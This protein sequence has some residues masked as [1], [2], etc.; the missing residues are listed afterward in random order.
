MANFLQIILQK[1]KDRIQRTVADRGLDPRNLVLMAN[2]GGLGMF[3]ENEQGDRHVRIFDDPEIFPSLREIAPKVQSGPGV[4]LAPFMQ[5]MNLRTLVARSFSRVK[6]I[7]KK[8]P[9]FHVSDF[10]AYDTSVDMCIGLDEF[11][12][13]VDEKRDDFASDRDMIAHIVRFHTT[14]VCAIQKLGVLKKPIFPEYQDENGP[15]ETQ[16]ILTIP[17]K[18][19]NKSR[20][21]VRDWE[22]DTPNAHSFMGMQSA[23]NIPPVPECGQQAASNE[24]RKRRVEIFTPDDLHVSM[25]TSAV[26]EMEKHLPADI[27]RKTY[28]ARVRKNH[29]SNG[30]GR[31][32]EDFLEAAA[33]HRKPVRKLLERAHVLYVPG[34]ANPDHAIR[35]AYQYLLVLSGIVQNQIHLP[36]APRIIVENGPFAQDLRE[37]ILWLKNVSMVGQRLDDLLSFTQDPQ[38]SAH[39]IATHAR[40]FVRQQK[41]ARAFVW[42]RVREVANT[43]TV[44]AYGSA[45]STDY[46]GNREAE[47]LGYWLAVNGY[48]LKTG[49][50]KEGRMK[51]V[52]DGFLKG[53]SDL[54]EAGIETPGQLILIQCHATQT[55]EGVYVPPE[56][57]TVNNRDIIRRCYHHIEER[58]Y[59]LQA[60]DASVALSGGIGTVE[61]IICEMISAAEDPEAKGGDQYLTLMFNQKAQVAGQELGVWDRLRESLSPVMS[62]VPAHIHESLEAIQAHLD[63]RREE[64]NAK[65]AELFIPSR[66]YTGWGLEQ[67][68]R[69]G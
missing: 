44:T 52:A 27:I 15:V 22:R 42:N 9:E 23:L 6:E 19:W 68:R 57:I 55:L 12:H 36:N 61:E 11:F 66:H 24:Q 35:M 56:D 43:M 18:D 65:G 69:L 63:A 59:D 53:K 3:L 21:E 38:E 54:S 51:A 40:T 37:N 46:V 41:K 29:V 67:S 33:D 30:G 2:D 20:A 7:A 14:V 1:G 4:E 28:P 45:T 48:S 47:T 17:G 31:I 8:N 13:L 60:N 58:R 5:A 39:I 62:L 34:D 10:G 64:K 25:P 49:G 26:R 32:Q 50:G 16:H